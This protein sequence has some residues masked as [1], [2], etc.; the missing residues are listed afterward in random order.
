MMLLCFLSLF[1]FG[2][3]FSLFGYGLAFG[4]KENDT[5]FGTKYFFMIGLEKDEKY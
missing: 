1:A 2:I 5:L 4:K 3:N